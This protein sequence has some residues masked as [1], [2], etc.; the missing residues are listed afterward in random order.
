MSIDEK[1]LKQEKLHD[2]LVQKHPVLFSQHR[3]GQKHTPFSHS[4]FQ[5][6]AGWLNIIDNLATS[7]EKLCPDDVASIEVIQVKEKFGG[8]RFYY[9]FAKTSNID[10][11]TKNQIE[12][13]VKKAEDRC[14]N[15]CEACGEPGQLRKGNWL[16]VLCD[17]HHQ[18]QQDA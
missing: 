17:T 1:T 3:S 6:G 2:Q 18:Q 9:G 5:I 7:I 16:R 14:L 13:L 10:Q 11:E 4:G 15:T 8:L 12:Q